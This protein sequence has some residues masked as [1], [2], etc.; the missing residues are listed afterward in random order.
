MIVLIVFIS[1]TKYIVKYLVSLFLDVLLLYE[2]YDLYRKGYD[3]LKFVGYHEWGGT[4]LKY[5][6]IKYLDMD[7]Y[8]FKNKYLYVYVVSFL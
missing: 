7:V 1:L 8:F 4:K 3:F 2:K 5:K 6:E